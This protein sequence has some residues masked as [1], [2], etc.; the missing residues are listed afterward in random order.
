MKKIAAIVQ[1]R[2]SSS[3]LPQ[4]VLMDLQGKPVIEQVCHQL[5]YSKL[6]NEI[7]LATSSDSSDDPLIEWAKSKQI[8]YFRGD[9]NNVL[10]RFYDTAKYFNIEVI[11]R[12]TADCPL[13]DPEIVDNVIEQYLNGNHDYF[14]NTNPPTFPD[15]LDTEVFSF[16]SLEK[17]FH[18]AEL[19]SEIE[20]VTP[21]I[22]NHAE[23][24]KIGNYSSPINDERLRWTLDNEEDYKFI[25]TVYKNLFDK[26]TYIAWR[27]VLKFLDANKEVIGINQH[28]ARN[29]GLTKSLKTDKIIKR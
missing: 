20:H 26:N 24:F 21:F 4:K 1:A 13:I 10:K 5:S 29:E 17:A 15:G 11:V 2:M 9:L 27:D 14:S 23:I 12:I 28:I 7:I 6:L 3:R 25:S 19:L 18:Q 8:K 22:R 16:T